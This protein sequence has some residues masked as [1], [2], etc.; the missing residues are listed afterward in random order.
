MEIYY[1][2]LPNLFV[3]PQNYSIYTKDIVFVNNLRGVTTV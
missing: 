2:Q 1:L 3:K